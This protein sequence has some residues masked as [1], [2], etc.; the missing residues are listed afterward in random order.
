MIILLDGCLDQPNHHPPH[1]GPSRDQGMRGVVD[2]G[3][4]PENLFLLK[5]EYLKL[6]CRRRGLAAMNGPR[7]GSTKA[8]LRVIDL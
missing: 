5:Y 7:Q 4:N 3:E 2:A 6:P 1:L 8:W